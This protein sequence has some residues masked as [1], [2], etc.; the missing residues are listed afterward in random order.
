MISA[1]VSFMDFSIGNW[2][3]ILR[4][5]DAGPYSPDPAELFLLYG[6]GGIGEPGFTE[7]KPWGI[8]IS[9]EDYI[10]GHAFRF[11]CAKFSKQ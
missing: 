11:P 4:N 8:W 3:D 2:L 1:S 5:Q 7:W 9:R 10:F 6:V